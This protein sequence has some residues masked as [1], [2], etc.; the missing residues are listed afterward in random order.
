MTTFS[1]AAEVAEV[2]TMVSSS[3][4]IL[5]LHNFI[6]IPQIPLQASICIH[7]AP[8]HAKEMLMER[9]VL[10]ERCELALPDERER[11]LERSWTWGI[12]WRMICWHNVV[13][14]YF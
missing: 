14:L 12:R 3:P 9:C 10:Y 4:R 2:L 11:H 5:N 7:R 13:L 6:A 8:F 1:Q